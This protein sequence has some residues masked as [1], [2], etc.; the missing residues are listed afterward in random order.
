MYVYIIYQDNLTHTPTLSLPCQPYG[1]S[2]MKATDTA[3]FTLPYTS[4]VQC[5]NTKLLK[6]EKTIQVGEVWYGI[7]TSED[8]LA[9]GKK[10]EIRIFRKTGKNIKTIVLKEM[11]YC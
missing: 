9:L 1:I 7:T 3:A 4:Y 6:V 5:I 8:F 2:I 10:D 11:V